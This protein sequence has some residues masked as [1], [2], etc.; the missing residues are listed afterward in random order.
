MSS[1][2]KTLMVS[3]MITAILL[4][5]CPCQLQ[6]L[7]A[8]EVFKICT[9]EAGGKQPA[10]LAVV[11]NQ[12]RPEDCHCE[13]TGRT[14]SEP[15]ASAHSLSHDAYASFVLASIR[16]DEGRYKLTAIKEHPGRSPPHNI[17]GVQSFISL[18]FL[19]TYRI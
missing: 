17:Q 11:D 13:E 1:S 5:S 2:L 19:C 4:P 15:N 3:I 16:E 18:A 7:L 10:S 12:V 6:K 8:G 14:F 9:V